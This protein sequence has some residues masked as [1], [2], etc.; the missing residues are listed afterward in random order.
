MWGFLSR[1]TCSQRNRHNCEPKVVKLW[2]K[3]CSSED[4]S[5]VP[6]ILL[7]CYDNG[8]LMSMAYQ[9]I[10]GPTWNQCEKRST[11]VRFCVQLTRTTPI[12]YLGLNLRHL[13]N[14]WVYE[15][16]H[17]T[18]HGIWRI[19]S[20]RQEGIQTPEVTNDLYIDDDP[21]YA[22]TADVSSTRCAFK[23][24]AAEGICPLHVIKI[25]RSVLRRTGEFLPTRK[26][27][28]WSC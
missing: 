22:K 9:D 4:T 28:R 21:V 13:I 16:V 12:H 8:D 5:A 1:T 15:D 14:A 17:R 25:L 19:L 24:P 3:T 2:T 27:S 23:A 11:R 26:K 20:F 6:T 7:A 10:R 18:H